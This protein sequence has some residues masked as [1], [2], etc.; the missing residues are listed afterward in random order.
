MPDANPDEFGRFWARGNPDGF[1]RIH[2]AQM[3][4]PD[5]DPLT[6]QPILHRSILAITFEKF[7]ASDVL[8]EVH[9]KA[10]PVSR[11]TLSLGGSM[12]QLKRRN[13]K[14]RQ[15]NWTLKRKRRNPTS[16]LYFEAPES[17]RSDLA[18]TWGFGPAEDSE[19]EEGA[20]KVKD[21][22]TERDPR[23]LQ[24]IR[25]Q[26]SFCSFKSR[27]GGGGE[28]P[29]VFLRHQ[30]AN[31]ELIA[32]TRAYSMSQESR[33]VASV[34]G[35]GKKEGSIELMPSLMLHRAETLLE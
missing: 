18:K 35:G 34:E 29:R 1:G 27:L 22:P 4:N 25:F 16:S 24:A 14:K 7:P 8:P 5:E 26:R 31:H 17:A 30:R 2:T 12:Q 32:R 15:R 10:A 3:S 6:S 20:I 33:A 23:Q 21:Q 13:L 9:A 19:A 28:D 11:T